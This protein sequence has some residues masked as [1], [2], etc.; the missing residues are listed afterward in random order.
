VEFDIGRLK[1]LTAKNL[2]EP[3]RE[4]TFTESVQ[5]IVSRVQTIAEQ[6]AKVGRSEAVCICDE[7]VWKPYQCGFWL[8]TWLTVR[9]ECQKHIDKHYSDSDNVSGPAKEAIE[10][11]RKS[12]FSSVTP[13]PYEG[14]SYI[15]VTW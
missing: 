14:N 5:E 10:L 9:G 7:I 11:L 3:Q 4:P 1:K 6:A 2:K 15:R 8:D 13:Y 12:G